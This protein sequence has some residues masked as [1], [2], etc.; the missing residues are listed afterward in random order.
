M[1]SVILAVRQFTRAIRYAWRDPSFQLLALITG[2]ILLIGTGFYHWVEGWGWLDS[3]YF[4]VITLATVGYGDFAPQTNAG[5]IFT[6]LYIFLGIGL[7]VGVFTR[8]AEAL[9]AAQ[10]DHLDNRAKRRQ[11]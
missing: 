9:L 7:L 2:G 1:I 3:L 4:C 11:S 5:K 8:L 6:M 10:R